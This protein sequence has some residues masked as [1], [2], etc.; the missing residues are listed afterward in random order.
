[1][2]VR[3]ERAEYPTYWYAKHIGETFEVEQ[4]DSKSY[5]LAEDKPTAIWRMIE[6]S[7]CVVLTGDKS[8]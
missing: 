4:Y 8:A 7:D 5:V 6:V 1:M 2:K 3:I